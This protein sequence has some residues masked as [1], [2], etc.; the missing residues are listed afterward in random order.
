VE[1]D[2]PQAAWLDA[3]WQRALDNWND[4]TRHAV[5]IEQALRTETLP[6][7][8]GRY[9]ALLEDAD[10]GERAKKQIDAIVLAA[11]SLLLSKKTPAP[12]KTPLPITLSAV[13][14]CVF[15]LS[16]LAWALFPHR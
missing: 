16:W 1:P 9:R 6:E 8:A 14:V 3:S 15:L 4:D 12:G 7:L 11:T 2:D 10:K 13:G 5:L